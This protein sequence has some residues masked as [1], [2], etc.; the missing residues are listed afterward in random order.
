MPWRKDFCDTQWC[1]VLERTDCGGFR[2]TRRVTPEDF[3]LSQDAAKIAKVSVM[4]I[5]NWR[6]S[7]RLKSVSQYSEHSP[8]RYVFQVKDVLKAAQRV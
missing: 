8:V 2:Y 7:G 1:F 6:V 5:H 3:V 4:T